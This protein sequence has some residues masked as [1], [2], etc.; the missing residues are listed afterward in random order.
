M[1]NASC[2]PNWS[3]DGQRILFETNLNGNTE[4]YLVDVALGSERRLTHNRSI[5]SWAVW[6]P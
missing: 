5:D 4:L 1:S 6:R 3:P 2:C